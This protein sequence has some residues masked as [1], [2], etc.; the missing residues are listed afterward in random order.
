MKKVLITGSTGFLGKHLKKYI[1]LMLEWDISECNSSIGNLLT[2]DNLSIYNNISFDYIFHLAAKTKAGDYCMYHKG[3]Q[4]IDNQLLNTNILKYWVNEQPQAKMV[5]MGTSCMYE[6]TDKPLIEHDCI[7][8]DTEPGLY[9]YAHTKRMLL[10]GL[11]SIAEQYGLKYLY[12][13]PST[14]Y[15][16]EF[17]LNDSHFIFDLI[18]KIY[19]GKYNG[20]DVTLWGNGHQRR[21]LIYVKDA[22]HIM[23]KLL[24]VDDHVINIGTGQDHSIREYANS[25]CNV[26]GYDQDKIMYD[27]SRYT[28]AKIKR[29][30]TEKLLSY[31]PNDFT[32]TSIEDG[33]HD[34]I[35]YYINARK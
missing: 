16:P 11:Q 1:S 13:L 29:L 7:K 26:I 25:I 12:L 28:G 4:W 24:G 3:E 33:L 20:D 8:G 27:T 21:E 35:D 22:V 19:N 9:A 14:L 15:G 17:V 31:L 32:F 6:P 23:M 10:I 34:T 18:K 30:C 5:A 2:Y